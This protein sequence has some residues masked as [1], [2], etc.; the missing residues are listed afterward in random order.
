M[1]WS[2]V[3]N[4]G[5]GDYGDSSAFGDYG[6]SSAFG[7]YGDSS[8]FGDYGDSSDFGDYG[9]SSAFGDYGDENTSSNNKGCDECSSRGK[10]RPDAKEFQ[11]QIDWFL[12]DVPGT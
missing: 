10:S 2:T 1:P 5:F 6:D 3:G 9:D 7:D 4:D 11:N 12:N 8:A